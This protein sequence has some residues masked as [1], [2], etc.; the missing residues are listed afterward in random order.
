MENMVGELHP[1]ENP[2][3]HRGLGEL[4]MNRMYQPEMAE[5]DMGEGQMG[6]EEEQPE[7]GETGMGG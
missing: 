3:V 4:G 1:G 2:Q 6:Y 7:M 5:N